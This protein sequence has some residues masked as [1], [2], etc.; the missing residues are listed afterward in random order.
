[1]INTKLPNK[2]EWA[3]KIDSIREMMGI[4]KIIL[5][6]KSNISA[7]TLYTILKGES[8]Y[9]QLKNLENG[10]KKCIREKV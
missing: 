4:P 9:E 8:S 5:A 1:M 10:L 6:E 2:Q 3:D 7:P